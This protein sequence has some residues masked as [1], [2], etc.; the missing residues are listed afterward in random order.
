DFSSRRRSIRG[1]AAPPAEARIR[2][3]F[4]Q[5]RYGGGGFRS[6]TSHRLERLDARLS[7]ND[8]RSA[9]KQ[10]DYAIDKTALHQRPCLPLAACKR[11]GDDRVGKRPDIHGY[12]K[13][14]Q[15]AVIL[16]EP[17]R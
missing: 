17:R 5:P 10:Q 15:V 11:F 1:A 2:A 8:T 3:G 14:S 6:A 13:V 12:E 9:L 16:D 7:A 4:P